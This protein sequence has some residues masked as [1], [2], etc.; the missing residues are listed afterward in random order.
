MTEPLPLP[1]A[2]ALIV[3]HGSLLVAV[4]PH[5]VAAVTATVPV[6][7]A[8]VGLADA[9]E[10]VGVHGAP[11]WVIVNVLA[12]IVSVAVRDVVLGLAETL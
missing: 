3:I 7:A 10:M 11:A 6:P 9:G 8:A 4:H 1:V 2:P 12:P 5:P